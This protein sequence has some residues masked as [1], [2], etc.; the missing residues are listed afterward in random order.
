MDL[1]DIKA[2]EF[3]GDQQTHYNNMVTGEKQRRVAHRLKYIRQKTH[4]GS[5]TKVSVK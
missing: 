5:L 1:A 3:G 4:G 2:K